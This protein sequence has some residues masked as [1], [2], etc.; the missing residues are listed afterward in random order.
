[1][2]DVSL[3]SWGALLAGVLILRFAGKAAPTQ[4][5]FA[6]MALPIPFLFIGF[7]APEWNEMLREGA[8]GYT[9][10]LLGVLFIDRFFLWHRWQRPSPQQ[11]PLQMARHFPS[12]PLSQNHPVNLSIHLQSMW[13]VPLQGWAWE[14]LPPSFQSPSSST[15]GIS[16]QNIPIFF[17]LPPKGETTLLLPT[18]PTQRGDFHWKSLWL[19]IQSPLSLLWIQTHIQQSFQVSVYPDLAKIQGLSLKFSK[20]NRVGTLPKRLQSNEG[21][22]FQGLKG[23]ASGDDIK[24]MDWKASARL[25]TP[26][27]RVFSPEVEQPIL[28]VLDQSR[29]MAETVLGQPKFDWALNAALCF[30]SVSL[31]RGEE[32]GA[33]SFRQS[34]L[35]FYGTGKG[36]NQLNQLLAQLYAL[37]PEEGVAE[38]EKICLTLKK[39]L[40]RPT[41]LVIFTEVVDALASH[42]LIKGLQHL[43][44]QH[45]VMVVTLKN[46]EIQK[47][48]QNT[49]A[50]PEKLYTQAVAQDFLA[51][52]QQALKDLAKHPRILSIDAEPDKIEVA[53]LQAYMENKF[54]KQHHTS[55][56]R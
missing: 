32:C 25:D 2:E 6:L 36:K 3:W 45:L 51:L 16:P 49:M 37:H 34:D 48:A 4:K 8:Q 20:N 54:H 17:N 41:L 40:K 29:A 22:L 33:G 24:K 52:R 1:M 42:S 12:T 10:C 26:I 35:E 55:P 15:T 46:P 31:Q 13:D 44:N 30:A 39:I 9:Y 43:A 56:A 14:S 27:I 5:L 21:H 38:Y 18:L 53:L 50:T 11:P 47:I 28:L 7:F 19:R 23:Y